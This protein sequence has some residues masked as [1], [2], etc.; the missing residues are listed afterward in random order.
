MELKNAIKSRISVRGFKKDPVSKEILTEIIQTSLRAPSGLNTQPWDITVVTGAVL[1]KVRQGIVDTLNSGGKP[2]PDFPAQAKQ[3]EG[4]YKERQRALGFELYRLL[5]IGRDDK[6]KKIE[7]TMHGF[8]SF[9]A[10]AAIY[11]SMNESLIDSAV[12][13]FA[14]SDLGGLAQTIC[15]V[16]LEYGLGT[17]IHDQGVMF[18][19]VVHKVAGIPTSKKLHLCISVGYPD[20][21]H[22]ANKLVT[23]RESVEKIVEWIG[24]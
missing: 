7:W 23:D 1:E 18:S 5:G 19:E 12:M 3:L 15:L 9:E 8:R 16:A 20:W 22:P 11:L 14:I 6:K 2:E 24:F 21:D 13:R 4:V 10:P 17:C